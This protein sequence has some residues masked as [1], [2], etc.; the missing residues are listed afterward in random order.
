MNFHRDALADTIFVDAGAERHDRAHI[1]VAGREILVKWLAAL[2]QSRRAVID[3]FEI[4]G[5]YRYCID[6]HQDFGALG[7]RD[8]L[9]GELK[10][11]GIAENPGFHSVGDRKI[12]ARLHARSGIH[13]L[14]SLR[15]DFRYRF[16]SARILVQHH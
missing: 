2:D 8:G 6:A 9:L 1:F 10:L 12:S 5:A 11:A 16:S 14:C 7:R 4:G 15:P 3:D 13:R